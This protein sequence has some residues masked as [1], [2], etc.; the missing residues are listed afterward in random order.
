MALVKVM[1]KFSDS[2]AVNVLY[3]GAGRGALID[4]AINAA[5]KT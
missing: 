5:E 2:L 3:V 4:R 1:R